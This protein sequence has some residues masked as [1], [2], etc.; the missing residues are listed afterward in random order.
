[1]T[2]NKSEEA[3]PL[4]PLPSTEQGAAP[5]MDEANNE[6]QADNSAAPQN[7]A[8]TPKPSADNKKEDNQT[9]DKKDAGADDKVEWMQTLQKEIVEEGFTYT[10]IKKGI[11]KIADKFGSGGGDG[12]TGPDQKSSTSQTPDVD[13]TPTKTL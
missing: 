3:P 5:Q 1:M 8:P 2:Q 12:G 11:E 7:T 13:D 4:S 6:D 10:N 9:E